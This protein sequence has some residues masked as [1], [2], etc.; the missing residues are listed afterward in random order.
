METRHVVLTGPM[1]SGKTVIGAQLARDLRRPF[2]DSDASIEAAV[3]LNAREIAERDGVRQL[4]EL[5]WRF[6]ETALVKSEGAVVAAA[7][8]V[9]DRPAQLAQVIDAGHALVVLDVNA[10][11]LAERRRVGRHRRP[12]TE[13]QALRLQAA[14][15]KTVVDVGGLCLEL[16]EESDVSEAAL[17][18]AT[19]LELG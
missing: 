7:A 11:T 8:S 14:R 3:G 13:T 19:L 15:R 5:E 2:H 10:T 18:I 4:H 1:G 9:A 16:V 6:L 17:R 12:L